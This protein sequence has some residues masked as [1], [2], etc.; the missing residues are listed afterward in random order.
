MWLFHSLNFVLLLDFIVCV[1]SP[2]HP[3]VFYIFHLPLTDSVHLPN[4]SLSITLIALGKHSGNIVCMPCRI[5][6]TPH[7]VKY[8]CSFSPMRMCTHTYMHALTRMHTLAY[9]HMHTR[10][11]SLV[12]LLKWVSFTYLFLPLLTPSFNIFS[13]HYFLFSSLF[14]PLG[15]QLNWEGMRWLVREGKKNSSHPS[16]TVN[17]LR[18][19]IKPKSQKCCNGLYKGWWAGENKLPW[20]SEKPLISW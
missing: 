8:Y 15:R 11:K 18:G 17:D 10:V 16:Y 1:S 19:N 14:L 20:K 12:I 7:S 2:P 13:L 6:S 9:T 5:F 4:L 3:F